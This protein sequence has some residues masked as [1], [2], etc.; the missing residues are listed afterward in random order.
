MHYGGDHVHFDPGSSCL[1]ILDPLTEQPRPALAADL[2]RLMQV[3]EGLPEFAAQ[4]TA[5]VCN[6]VPG[7]MGDWFR[8]LLMLLHSDKPVVTG[9]FSAST[10]HVMLELLALDCGGSIN[11]EPG[12]APCS[13]Y[14]R[15]R[16]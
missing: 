9:A 14:A 11:S 6:D 3:T 2:I 8:L 4:S 5:M 13:T 12:L 7:E 16:R 1:N 10:L 15:R